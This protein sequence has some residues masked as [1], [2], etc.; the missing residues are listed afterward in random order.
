[1]ELYVCGL[2]MDYCVALTAK[3]AKKLGYQV[4]LVVDACRAVDF[5]P[6]DG[7]KA[8]R[9]LA[10]MGVILTESSQILAKERARGVGRVAELR[11]VA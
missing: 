2:A 1:M 7:V 5:S 8:L 4:Q 11:P 3:D 6:G 10:A 9:E